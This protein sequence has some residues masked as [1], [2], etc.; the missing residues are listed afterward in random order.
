MY[1]KKLFYTVILQVI[2]KKIYNFIICHLI[3]NINQVSLI[4]SFESQII[5]KMTIIS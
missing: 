4:T 5:F 1:Y 2:G 3:L